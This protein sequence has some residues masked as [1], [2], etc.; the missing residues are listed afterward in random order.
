MYTALFNQEAM[1]NLETPVALTDI[2]AEIAQEEQ[3]SASHLGWAALQGLYCTPIWSAATIGLA[4]GG[5]KHWLGAAITGYMAYSSFAAARRE[6]RAAISSRENA[7]NLRESIGNTAM[8]SM[9][10]LL[11]Q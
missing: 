8:L 9:E 7:D 3:S 6:R 10:M 5:P 2:E 4:V 1:R 11:A